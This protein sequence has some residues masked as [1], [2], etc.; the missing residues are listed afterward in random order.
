MNQSLKILIIDDSEDDTLLLIRELKRSGLNPIYKRVETRDAMTAV[1]ANETWE[2]II[3]DYKMPYF[4]VREALEV[5]KEQDIDIPFIIV[6]GTIGEETAVEVMKAGASD[7]IMKNNLR[8]LVPAINRELVEAE[9]RRKRRQAEEELRQSSDRLRKVLND[10]TYAIAA[11]T[12]MRDP[13]TAGHQR[14]VTQL[15]C[16]IASEMEI[17]QDQIEG[18]RVAGTLHDIGKIQVPAEILSKPCELTEYEFGII[19]S[20]PQSG[21]DI[22][23]SIEFPWPVAQ[24]VLQHHE[25]MNGSGYPQGL[26]EENILLE[27][28]ILSAADVIEAMSSHRPYRP[29]LGEGNALEYVAHNKGILFD[30]QVAEV[31]LR[32]FY[33]KGFKFE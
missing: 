32:T 4:N 18:L 6:S 26:S 13:Y 10:T 33:E 23:K 11:T 9:E 29:A 27:S 20:H 1:L 22:L 31:C 30:Q 12:E 2:V 7:Y 5:I 8:R 15:A 19:R 21:Y 16:A 24:I 14:R 28:K 25:R 17:S 3:S